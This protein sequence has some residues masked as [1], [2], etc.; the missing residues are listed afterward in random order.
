MSDPKNKLPAQST[1]SEVDAF[2]AKVATLPQQT[3]TQDRGR[4]LFAMD[5]TA[6][7]APTWDRACAIQ[8]EMFSETAALG[9]LSVQL[10]FYRGFR[11]FEASDWLAET[12]ALR[13]R[14]TQVHCAGGLTQIN[15]LLQ[16]AI[17]ENR[18]GKIN[19][20]VFVGDCFEEELDPVCNTAGELGL[21][22]VPVFVFHE[23]G[24]PEAARAFN[25]IA[26]LTHGAYSRFDSNSAAQLRA[27]LSA[28]AVYAV[29]GRR[30]LADFSKRQG[31][32]VRALTR[33]IK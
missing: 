30:A 16:H 23:G 32:A 21:L 17:D 20:M 24:N 13:T 4:L 25:D 27:L 28:V 26:R 7:R 10:C 22:G 11:E 19:A 2:L 14:M 5:A 15:R 1:Q 33:Q 9:E 18:K 8:G 12:Q 3:R 29:G 6:S 31:G